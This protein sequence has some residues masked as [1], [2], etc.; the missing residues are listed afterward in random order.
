[1]N[2]YARYLFF[3][4]I[5]FMLF[6][7]LFV[8][9]VYLYDP[10]QIF[11]KPYFRKTTF[12]DDMRI[13]AKGIIDF[14]DFDSYVVGTSMLHN[15]F[16]NEAREKLGGKWVNITM[17]GSS[18]RERKIVL[19]YILNHKKVHNIIYSL[20][21]FMYIF[22]PEI[23][24]IKD[25]LYN[26]T[27]LDDILLYTHDR[28][29]LCSLTWSKSERCIGQHHAES[30]EDSIMKNTTVPAIQMRYGGIENWM[31]V[32]EKVKDLVVQ[33][34]HIMASK[35]M[36]PESQTVPY[37]QQKIQDNILSI[38]KQYPETHFHLIIP[39]YS[40]FGY[41]TVLNTKKHHIILPWLV[42]EINKLPNA[43][44]YGFDDLDYADHIE[45]YWDLFHYG[46]DMT[47]MQLDAIRDGTHILTSHNIEEYL[48]IMQTKIDEYDAQSLIETIEAILQQRGIDL[49]SLQD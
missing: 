39:T 21:Y 45:N 17:C 27:W 12:H 4:P 11:H 33:I 1:M 9:N 31:K 40:R 22:E 47:S 29:I 20:D 24:P 2:K 28:F 14:Y 18:Y 48:N 38:I 41:K 26:D 34:K 37:I 49:E 7:M 43:T 42:S 10:A 19:R 36:F 32:F 5:F 8:F 16:A 3:I 46:T 30:I 23:L 35:S 13:A 25:F 6:S 44:L 15:V